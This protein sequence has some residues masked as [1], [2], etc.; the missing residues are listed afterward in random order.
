MFAEPRMKVD[1]DLQ[2]AGGENIELPGPSVDVIS[3]TALNA[4]NAMG[5]CG[6]RWA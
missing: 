5:W 3:R 1:P 6:V 2:K 4:I